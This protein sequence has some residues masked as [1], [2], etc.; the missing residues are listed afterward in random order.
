MTAKPAVTTVRVLSDEGHLFLIL[1]TD[2]LWETMSPQDAVDLVG[3]WLDRKKMIPV[4]VKPGVPI[5]IAFNLRPG[6]DLELNGKEGVAK[7]KPK[8]TALGRERRCKFEAVN[9]TAQDENPAVHLVRNALGGADEE[10]VRGALTF[11]YPSC[12]TIRDDI[13]V[14]V[15]FFNPEH[16]TSI[17]R[18]LWELAW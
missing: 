13:T 17:F 16:R 2:G 7:P 4:P 15:V 14:Q 9:A 10:T 5:E 12:K 6:T 1:A 18:E 8:P 11:R 3:W